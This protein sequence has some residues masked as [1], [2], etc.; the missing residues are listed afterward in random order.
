MGGHD[1]KKKKKKAGGTTTS[2]TK[3]TSAAA[4]AAKAPSQADSG[5][6]DPV[7]LPGV[8]EENTLAVDAPLA[9]TADASEMRIESVEQPSIDDIDPMSSFPEIPE[10]I[11]QDA[12]D[13]AQPASDE[14]AHLVCVCS[15]SSVP[16]GLEEP[17]QGVVVSHPASEPEA[18]TT[19]LHAPEEDVQGAFGASASMVRVTSLLH[20]RCFFTVTSQSTPERVP[21][22]L[23]LGKRVTHHCNS[24]WRSLT[25]RIGLFAGDRD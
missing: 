6:E 18:E 14:S 19:A 9:I 8:E 10:S 22:R 13:A 11:E 17:M 21:G 5:A 20:L 25:L 3:T 16:E 15:D 12:A 24:H 1:K 4:D 23:S 7:T 2:P